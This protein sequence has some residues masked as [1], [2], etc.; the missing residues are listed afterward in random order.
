VNSAAKS[1]TLPRSAQQSIGSRR[2]THAS[3]MHEVTALPDDCRRS[4]LHYNSIK[5]H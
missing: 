3:L 1:G 2:E 5:K 4:L